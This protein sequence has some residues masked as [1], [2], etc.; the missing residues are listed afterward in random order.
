[1][2][3]T[4]LQRPEP[5]VRQV[6]LPAAARALS[7]LPRID[8]EDAFRVDI[9][10]AAG[11][12]AE[13]WA[14]AVL[15][16]APGSVQERLRRGW[17]TLGLRLAGPGTAGTVLG[18]Q[19]RRSTPDHALLG[20]RSRLGM[21]AELLFRPD[22]DTLL[23]ATLVQHRNGVARAIWARVAARHVQVVPRLLQRAAEQQGAGD[24]GGAQPTLTPK[25]SAMPRS[26]EV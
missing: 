6:E 26:P 14:R 13:Q 20:A 12:T 3:P 24:G 22:Q 25:S 10:P 5:T 7:T 8:Y 23:F 19:L 2:T 11:W 16:G 17:F 21:P 18:W 15:E 4:P 1:M 9:D